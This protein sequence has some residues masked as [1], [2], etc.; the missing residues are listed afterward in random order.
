MALL[1]DFSSTVIT[2]NFIQLM[3]IRHGY[4]SGMS[5]VRQGSIRDTTDSTST[6]IHHAHNRHAFNLIEELDC[7]GSSQKKL[8]LR[9]FLRGRWAG[10]H[11]LGCIDSTNVVF[12]QKTANSLIPSMCDD[13]CFWLFDSASCNKNRTSFIISRGFKFDPKTES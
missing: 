5:R 4:F 7:H 6:W 11:R 13:V 2:N 1:P 10:I 9:F 8:Y 12:L 3:L